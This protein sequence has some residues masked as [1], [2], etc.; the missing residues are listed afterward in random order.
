MEGVACFSGLVFDDKKKIVSLDNLTKIW[1]RSSPEAAKAVKAGV[2]SG[3]G[4]N[5][6]KIFIIKF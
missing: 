4:F 5:S 6:K 1:P 3:A 2:N